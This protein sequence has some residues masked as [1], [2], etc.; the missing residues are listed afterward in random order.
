MAFWYF[1]P[2][3]LAQEKTSFVLC[4]HTLNPSTGLAI[5]QVA[6]HAEWSQGVDEGQSLITTGKTALLSG[7][8]PGG[9][10]RCRK[11][12]YNVQA[13][14][15]FYKEISLPP[16]SR[17]QVQLSSGPNPQPAV[18]TPR[19][20]FRGCQP[21]SADMLGKHTFPLNASTQQS[22]ESRRTQSNFSVNPTMLWKDTV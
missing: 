13:G 16:G 11:P 20:P 2:H 3:G 17:V 21:C 4:G 19:L 1:S 8:L 22:G 7:E 12:T 10:P 6:L 5:W 9:L 15:R 18:Q 14:P